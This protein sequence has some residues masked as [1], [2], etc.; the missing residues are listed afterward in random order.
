MLN[1]QPVKKRHGKFCPYTEGNVTFGISNR[2]N[3]CIMATKDDREYRKELYSFYVAYLL[4][5]LVQQAFNRRM[6]PFQ[7]FRKNTPGTGATTAADFL[8]MI[9]T[10]MEED[11]FWRH[12][13]LARSRELQCIRQ[14]GTIWA[15]LVR[16]RRWY[17]L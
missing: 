6:V 17:Q 12:L 10:V 1:G 14:P 8:G 15:S 9:F 4:T 5:P 13:P 3:A 16:G 11:C 2:V 7:L